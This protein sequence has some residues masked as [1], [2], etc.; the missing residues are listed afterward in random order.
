MTRSLKNVGAM[1]IFVEDTGR[2]KAFYQGLL[3]LPIAFEDENSVGFDIGNTIL[4]FLKYSEAPELIAPAPVAKPGAGGQFQLT[5]FVENTDA[6]IADLEAAGVTL[7][8]GPI[9]RPWGMR[10]ACF[11]D[12]DGYVW[13]IAQNIGG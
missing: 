3:G 13:E 1:T 10:T 11:T 7:L 4:N 6:V 8:N 2:T 12:P 5:I 9:D